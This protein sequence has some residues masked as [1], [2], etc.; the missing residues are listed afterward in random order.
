MQN[1]KIK[2]VVHLYLGDITLSIW[3]SKN[4]KGSDR[5]FGMI[6]VGGS[7]DR[8]KSCVWDNIDFF[9]D[10]TN[11][12]FKKECGEELERKGFHIDD[13]RR[14]IRRLINRAKKQNIII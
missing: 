10:M 14:V 4:F 1:D 7:A 8:E 11:A 13:T 12:D 3:T 6:E 2:Y 5:N 9:V